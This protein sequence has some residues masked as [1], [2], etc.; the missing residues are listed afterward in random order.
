MGKA[1]LDAWSDLKHK[2]RT[3]ERLFDYWVRGRIVKKK[4]PRWSI[5]RN[6]LGWIE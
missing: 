4:A 3:I 1:L 5:V 6:V 2:D